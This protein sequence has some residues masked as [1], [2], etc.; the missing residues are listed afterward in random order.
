V[1]NQLE[2]S[3]SMEA[4]NPRLIGISGPFKGRTLPLTPGELSIG[5]ESSN[6]FWVNDSL[7]SRRHCVLAS[8][9]EDYVVRDLKSRNGTFVNGSAIEEW[10]LEHGDQIFVGDSTLMFLL[11][12]RPTKLERNPVRIAET[13][14]LGPST[15]VLREEDALYLHSRGAAVAENSRAANDL[16]FLLRLAMGIGAIRDW[17]S[18]QWQL[19]GFIFDAVPAGRGAVLLYENPEAVSSIAAWDKLGGPGLTV[20]ISRTVLRYVHNQRVGLLVNDAAS[21]GALAAASSLGDPEI[22]TVLC[23]PLTVGERV[24]G[25]IYL[26]S[27]T[28]YFEEHH[29]QIMTAVAA[30]TSL[31]LENILRWTSLKN[32]NQELRT[33]LEIEHDMVG[34]SPRMREVFEVIRKVAPMDSTVLILGE[35]G[36][37][38]ELVARA[39]HRNSPRAKETFVAINCAT[40]SESLLESELFGHE[41]GAFTGALA[42]KRGKLEVASGGTLFLDEV[43]EMAPLLQAKLL[44]VL[45]EREFERVGGTKP[46]KVDV[47]VVAATNKSLPEAVAAGSFRQDFFYRLN[48]VS[49]ALPPLRERREDILAL[50][51]H[52]I[53]R[54]SRKCGMRIRPLSD[55]AR[56]CLLNYEW[57]G[58]VRELENAI[59]RAMVLGSGDRIEPDDLP[60]DVVESNLPGNSPPKYHGAVRDLKKQLVARAFEESKGNYIEAARSLGMHPN[61]F[62]RLLRKLGL[63]SPAPNLQ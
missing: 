19:L 55:E 36:T 12:D 49:L 11:D 42:Q 58:N 56:A 3:N 23:V 61:S 32:E 21:A 20:R 29:L 39:L 60:E 22:Q 30:I 43:S 57:P 52:F 15:V 41:K 53:A 16:N 5:R 7:L 26:D 27:K 17:E 48:V 59:E 33:Q 24:L 6:H 44:R 54:V 25:A 9:G 28:T 38:K 4:L 62:L 10:Y 2:A 47:R 46:I 1:L 14:D 37:G 45:Q 34:A 8:E 63:R 13:A 31:A 35:S 40:L 18:L 50:A 51:E